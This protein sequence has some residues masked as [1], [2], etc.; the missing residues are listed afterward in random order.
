[1]SFATS[2]ETVEKT[3][4]ASAEMP[5][6][7]AVKEATARHQLKNLSRRNSVVTFETSTTVTT[8]DDEI[9]TPESHAI[10]T[11]M[12]QGGI[13]EDLVLLSESAKA[14]QPPTPLTLSAFR[15]SSVQLTPADPNKKLGDYY[16]LRQT[17]ASGILGHG[18]FST[19][20]MAVRKGEEVRVAVKSIAKHEAL[21]ARRVRVDGGKHHMEEWEILKKMRNHPFIINLHEVFETEEEIQLVMEYCEGGELF[22]AIQRKRNRK[23]AMRRGQYT[24]TQ[25]AVITSQILKAL[26][27]L[28]AAGIVHRD[29]KPE[30]IL[31]TD[32]HD[33]NRIRVKLC[34]FG[35]A[36]SIRGGDS[37]SSGSKSG[38]ASPLTPGRSRS[39]SMVGSNYYVA[40]EIVVGNPY[41]TAVDIYSL[42]VTLYILLCGFPPVFANSEEVIFPNAYWKDISEGAKDLL[43]KMLQ[44]NPLQ[45][46]T[47]REALRDKWIWKHLQSS[48]HRPTVLKPRVAR[49]TSPERC[50]NLDLVRNQLYQNLSLQASMKREAATPVLSAASPPK[51]HRMN[52]R[53]SSTLLALADLYREVAQSPSAQVLT[54]SAADATMAP[55]TPSPEGTTAMFGDCTSP[56]RALS[57]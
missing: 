42:G 6:C 38:E 17:G 4:A 55:K 24:E 50:S 7:E 9:D 52:R 11:A 19:V 37:S 54:V 21:R 32:N 14:Q 47:A 48:K 31:L 34:D 8:D 13:P 29:V 56:V 1:M 22:N 12:H 41:D 44:T 35:M 53:T 3:A 43:K 40:P 36:R 20:R 10:R 51:R 5:A 57:V 33:E 15:R 39:Y 30:N 45:R 25:A 27:D 23:N 2:P 28:H 18:A 49:L 46:I 26:A 16:E